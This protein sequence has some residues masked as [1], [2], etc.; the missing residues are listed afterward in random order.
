MNKILPG[1]LLAFAMSLA[2]PPLLSCNWDYR[3]WSKDRLSDTPLFRVVWSDGEEAYRGYIDRE[4]NIAIPPVYS[5]RGNWEEDFLGGFTIVWMET[6]DGSGYRF[7]DSSGKLLDTPLLAWATDFSEGFAAVRLNNRKWGLINSSGEFVI[8]PTLDSSIVLSEGLSLK[9]S[10]DRLFG[11]VDKL[12]NQVI[13]PRFLTASRFSE[14]RAVV[15]EGGACWFFEAEGPCPIEAVQLPWFDRHRGR[16]EKAEEL[17]HCKFTFI[18]RAGA[19]IDGD[20]YDWAADFSGGLARVRRESADAGW[21]WGY[22]DLS[23]QPAI[24]FSFDKAKDFHEGLAAV[25]QDDLWGYINEDG[26]FVIPPRFQYAGDFSEGLAVVGD[27]SGFWFIDETGEAALPG[28]FRAAS[29]FAFGLAHV[30][31]KRKDR[32]D[33]V[34]AYIDREG[35]EVFRY[36]LESEYLWQSAAAYWAA[37]RRR[38]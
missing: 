13:P 33:R 27:S 11:Y 35:S 8:E 4:G 6:H 31:L 22:V 15:V 3:I 21:K 25:R 26:Y 14:G 1:V 38:R 9:S 7:L 29:R 19:S 23:G 34:W 16:D 17:P 12:G 32:H 30:E 37:Q 2:I 28:V 10:P 5:S 36:S 18:D 24:P 20:G